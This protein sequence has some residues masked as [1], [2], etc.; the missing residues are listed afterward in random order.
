MAVKGNLCCA[1]TYM[2]HATVPSIPLSLMQ[3]FCN[4]LYACSCSQPDAGTKDSIYIHKTQTLNKERAVLSASLCKVITTIILPIHTQTQTQ[5]CHGS[6]NQ[7]M[8]CRHWCPGSVPGRV[9]EICGGQSGTRANFSLSTPAFPHHHHYTYDT[10][11]FHSSTNEYHLSNWWCGRNA[12][13]N[14]L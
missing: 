12:H 11:I 4:N 6:N 1:A 10:H 7:F 5:P 3:V 14:K 9:C 2:G 13:T 8:A